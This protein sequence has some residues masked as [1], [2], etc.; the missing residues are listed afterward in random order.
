MASTGGVRGPS[1]C[2][3]WV[4]RR[5]PG[6]TPRPAGTRPRFRGSPT[7]SSVSLG[8]PWHYV[9]LLHLSGDKT[10]SPQLSQKSVGPSSGDLFGQTGIAGWAGRMVARSFLSNSTASLG[11]RDLRT[12]RSGRDI[13]SRRDN[14]VCTMQGASTTSFVESN[15]GVR[16]RE[17]V[18]TR[19][20]GLPLCR[21][22]VGKA[23]RT[24]DGEAAIATA[25]PRFL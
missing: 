14:L 11:P 2:C 24:L 16:G 25:D 7:A 19:V 10:A 22:T 8:G 15:R 23:D 5:H 20:L 6:F 13:G 18:S 17:D 1:R 9:E 3:R 4:S 21:I 12:I